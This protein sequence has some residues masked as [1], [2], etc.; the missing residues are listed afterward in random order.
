MVRS[1]A[2]GRYFTIFGRLFSIFLKNDLLPKWPF[3]CV[4]CCK[5]VV[6]RRYLLRRVHFR[7]VLVLFK[8]CL[9]RWILSCAGKKAPV[10]RW[11]RQWS[12]NLMF[13]Y[14][15]V[16]YLM[17]SIV[18]WRNWENAFFH[19]SQNF[20]GLKKPHRFWVDFLRAILTNLPRRVA[21]SQGG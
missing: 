14:K 3:L 19:F 7:G 1:A 21:I 2:P 17:K 16:Q 5:M 8:K 10:G 20:R 4:A 9:S 13:Q 15:V 12:R 11:S 6:F 18:F